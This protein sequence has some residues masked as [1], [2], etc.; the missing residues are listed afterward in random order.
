LAWLR[1]L[2]CGPRACALPAP[3][4][5]VPHPLP[6]TRPPP[7][8]PTPTPRPSQDPAAATGWDVVA[9]SDQNSDFGGSCG[10]CYEVKCDPMS[11]KD[12]YGNQARSVPPPPPPP[13]ASPTERGRGRRLRPGSPASHSA[14][15]LPHPL[16]VQ[17]DR[18]SVC[19]DQDASIVVMVTDTC[20]CW[21][22]LRAPLPPPAPRLSPPPPS[23]PQSC[24]LPRHRHS[25]NVVRSTLGPDLLLPL[26]SGPCPWSSIHPP[27]A[28]SS[29][30]PRHRPA[31]LAVAPPAQVPDKCVF[32][33]TVKTV[34]WLVGWGLLNISCLRP[35]L[36]GRQL[37]SL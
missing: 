26:V 21:C 13:P 7:V 9:P 15:T 24:L 8:P 16:I 35:C 14:L 32:K 34:G 3:R 25:P 20:P 19:Y 23:S 4:V 33:Q 10:K 29:F 22:G 30:V 36:C 6:P 18:T 27:S 11:L 5:P 31:G 37:G 17:L 12:G 28:A 1:P 2:P